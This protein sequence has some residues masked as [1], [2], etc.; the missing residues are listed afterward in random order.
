M[1]RSR[2]SPISRKRPSGAGAAGGLG[3]GLIAYLGAAIR[4]GVDVVAEVRGL[5]AA[6]AGADVCLT[7]EG[8]ID[9]QTL[10]GKTVHGVARCAREAGVPTIA[11]AGKIDAEVEPLLAESGVARSR[12]SIR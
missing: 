5:R 1:P 2:I 10:R 8:R 4:P 9:D 11:F 12:S 3:F 6:L 7:G